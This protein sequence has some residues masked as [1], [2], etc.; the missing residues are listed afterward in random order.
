[1]TRRSILIAFVALA[2]SSQAFA[3][4]PW[5]KNIAAAQK[6]AKEKKQLILVDM[7]AEWCGWCHRFEREVFPSQ[8]FQE[9]T[10]D[11]VLLRLDTEDKGEGTSFSRK[12]GVTQLPTFLLLA[13]DLTIAGVIRGYAPPAEFV[14]MLKETRTK[15]S[16]F[17]KKASTE[18]SF[19]KDYVKRLELAREYVERSAHDKSEPR[20]R[21]LMTEKGVPAV[22]R[23]EA[24]Y[25]LAM[26]YVLQNK[27]AEGSKTISEL[28]AVSKTGESVERARLLLGQILMSQG[29][30]LGAANELRSFK[31]D[32]PNSP[33][34]GNVD[35]VLPSIEKRLAAGK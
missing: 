21:K 6:V 10:D 14:K 34:I 30:L 22:I 17:V 32:F 7:F 26:S 31:K 3:G 2:L 5:H 13:P 9:A 24:Y 23:D 28:K 1:L 19:G 35:M 11:I 8:A 27:L 12:Y 4:G 18:A 29:N 25:Q 33:L 16:A 15:Y 20:L